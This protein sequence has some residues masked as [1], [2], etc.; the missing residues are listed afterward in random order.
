MKGDRPTGGG[1]AEAYRY[2]GF[3]CTIAGGVVVFMAGGWLFD[4]VLG[5]F[6]VLTIGGALVGAALSIATVYVK[7]RA[8]E[9]ERRRRGPGGR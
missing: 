5:W 3:G 1:L 4:R 2:S 9:E 6:P 8:D 7:L